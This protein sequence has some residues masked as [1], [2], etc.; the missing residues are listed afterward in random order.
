MRLSEL[1]LTLDDLDLGSVD[2]E[3]DKRLAEYFVTTPQATAAVKLQKS[4]FLGRKGAGRNQTKTITSYDARGRENSHTWS[5]DTP[6]VTRGWDDANR[7]LNISNSF[8][9]ISYAY[10][11]AGQVSQERSLVAGSGGANL[12]LSYCRYPSGDVSQVTYPNGSTVQRTYTARGQL[13]GVGWDTGRSTSYVYLSDGKVEHQDYSN[14]VRT[15][16]GYDGRGMISSVSH[17][18][19][20][21]NLAYR[22]YWRDERDRILGLKRGMTSSVNGMEDGHGDRFTYD[23]E[24]QLTVAQYRL[25]DPEHDPTGALRGDNFAYD[26]LGNRFGW[27]DI[28]SRG[29]MWIQ[30]RDDN[31]LNQYD[32]WH[33][34]YD[35]P[36]SQHWGSGIFHDDSFPAPVPSPSPP[37]AWVPP[38]NGVTMA[39]GWNVASYNAL[40]QPVAMWSFAYLGTPNFMWFGYDP[41]GRCVKRWKG[42]TAPGNQV[43]PPDTN[44][45]TYFYYDGW[46]LVQEGS[47]ANSPAARLYVHGGRVDE[48]V[49]SF[50]AS[51]N[52]W[53]F[54]HYDARGHCILLTDSSANI[55]EQYDY[56]AFGFPYCYTS[57][58]V[59]LRVD[60]RHGSPWGTRFLFTG[61][62]WLSDLGVYDFRNRLYQPELGRFLQPDPKEFA[63]GDYNLYRYCHNDPVNRSDP[64]GLLEADNEDKKLA[65]PTLVKDTYRPV[66]G[67]N[68]PVHIRVFNSG[69]WNDR[70]VANH[71][72]TG[73]E[74]QTGKGGLTKAEGSSNVSGNN[75]DLNLKVN[76][77]WD[78]KYAGTNV[79]TRELE[80]VQDFRTYEKGVWNGSVHASLAELGNFKGMVS[81]FSTKQWWAY[82]QSW[83]SHNLSAHPAIPTA[84]PEY[85]ETH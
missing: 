16:Y 80:H 65:E 61:R 60:H 7:L 13:K 77:Y 54:H 27:N 85:D 12:N 83:G 34:S 48:I 51:S 64:F 81:G 66:T 6:S 69:N 74:A 3:S 55:I 76:W 18:H 30:R 75:V 5:D 50:A 71:A 49:A 70:K 11:N 20:T 23:A 33:N 47:G 62:E 29:A 58:G 2:A 56:D 4:H 84:V 22:D 21:Q 57:G 28:A 26:A 45:A 1:T 14:G 78:P 9:T 24:G 63:A 68:I 25:Q 52:Q 32:S 35:P 31:R 53:A 17:K 43:P 82:D 73:L 44:P 10:D 37:W 39:D 40:N 19:G 42:P 79:V 72:T 15:D 46:S 36:S 67:S 8:S 41:L 59:M 38:G